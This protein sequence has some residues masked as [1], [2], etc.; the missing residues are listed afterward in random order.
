MW[1]VFLLGNCNYVM[2]LCED[3]GFCVD[4]I[5]GADIYNRVRLRVCDLVGKLFRAHVYAGLF[6][7]F[8]VMK[9][10][11]DDE[12]LRLMNSKLQAVSTYCKY[13]GDWELGW[14]R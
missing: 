10:L 7:K 8:G 11:T 3:F 6:R 9:P 2:E 4:G 12:A 13:L 1:F 14:V 5:S